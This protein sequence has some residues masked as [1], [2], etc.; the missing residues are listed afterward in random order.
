[1]KAL[2]YHGPGSRSWDDTPDP[3]I[4]AATDI[5]MRVDAVT[6]YGTDLHM[7]GTKHQ[8]LLPADALVP[9]GADREGGA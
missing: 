7:E 5:V 1:V 4:A 9:A 3:E 8:Q 6:I 2:V